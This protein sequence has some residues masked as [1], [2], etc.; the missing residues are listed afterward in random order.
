[1]ANATAEA[2]PAALVSDVIAF[3]V[4]VPL[5]DA[6]NAVA[7]RGNVAAAALGLATVLPVIRNTRLPDA[8]ISVVTASV[9]AF[10]AAVE[11]VTAIL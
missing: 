6:P 11:C 3:A 1:M 2:L 10:R 7:L 4:A 9:A 5:D 8:P